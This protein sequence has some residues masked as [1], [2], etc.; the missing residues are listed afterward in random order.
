L[1]SVGGASLLEDPASAQSQ[2]LQWIL[3]SASLSSY[4]Q[5]EILQRYVLAALYFSAFG[6]SWQNNEGWLTDRDECEWYTSE[7]DTNICN[8]RGEL[9][10]ID[11]DSNNV[12]GTI[13]WIDLALLSNQLLVVDFFQNSLSGTFSSQFGLLT[14]LVAIDLFSNQLSG[15][16]PTEMGLLRALRYQ[17]CDTNVLTGQIPTE[18]SGMTSLETLWLNNNLLSGPIPSELGL[19]SNLQNL[20]LRN[21]LVTGT[22]PQEICALN[23]E[24]LEVSCDMVECDCC[25]NAD[26]TPSNDPLLDLLISVSPDGGAAL[27]DTDSPQSA[28]LEWL[29]SPLNNAFLSDE[30]IIQRYALSTLY[31]ATNGEKWGSSFLWL[32]SADE[33][34]WFTSS[35]ANTICDAEGKIIELDIRENGLLGTLP[36]EVVLLADS[37]GE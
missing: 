14:S 24:N 27:R 33:C 32:T 6:D 18:I 15:T 30:R 3:S 34:I 23:L 19:M 22:M 29:R 13:P 26:C 10:E 25:T 16:L 4:S 35:K 36:S 37:I 17:D 31:Y 2:A 1:A 28:A 20:Y 8:D 12:G 5:F 9:D 11:L 21:N 7:T